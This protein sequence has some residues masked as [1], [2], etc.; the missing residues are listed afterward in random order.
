MSEEILN[1]LDDAPAFHQRYGDWALI[2]GAS[3]GIGAAFARQVAA[4]G[5]NCILVARNETALES[6]KA[7]LEAQHGIQALCVTQDLSAADATARLIEAT[8]TRQ[9]GLVIYNAGGDPFISQFLNTDAEHWMK[10]LRMNT[11]TVMDISHAFGG[12]MIE[13]GR[14]GLLLVGSHA[15][16]GGVRKLGMYSATKAFSLNLGESLWAEWKDRGV[17]VLNLLISTVDTPTMRETMQRLN[18]PNAMTMPLPQADD[19]ARLAL[20]ELRN[21]PTLIHPEDLAVAAGAASPGSLRR[22]HVMKK[23]TEAAQFI[24]ND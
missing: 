6:L 9:V 21:G 5:L 12:R 2:A 22:D 4:Q 15:A 23:S 20:Q 8:G 3:H 19:I 11:Q 18:I 17:D 7:E 24:G 13:R 10:L 1:Q 14:G 16:L